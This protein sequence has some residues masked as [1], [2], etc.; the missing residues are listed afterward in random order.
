MCYPCRLATYTQLGTRSELLRSI[1]LSN[2]D[3][4]VRFALRLRTGK[5][6]RDGNRRYA[7]TIM[8]E[9]DGN[10]RQ[11]GPRSSEAA[12]RCDGSGRPRCSEIEEAR[13]ALPEFSLT[14][15]LRSLLSLVL[16]ISSSSACRIFTP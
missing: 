10:R 6:G 9:R 2:S 13:K 15:S 1:S 11:S 5:V 4:R 7:V 3:S 14:S 12:L 8:S 16:S